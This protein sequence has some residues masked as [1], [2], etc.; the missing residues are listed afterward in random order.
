MQC[1][2]RPKSRFLF[3]FLILI[4]IA[5]TIAAGCWIFRLNSQITELQQQIKLSQA[6]ENEEQDNVQ[7]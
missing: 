4:V 2:T 6:N 5:E 3:G 7:Q 1:K